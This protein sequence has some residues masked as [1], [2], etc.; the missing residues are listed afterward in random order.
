VGAKI[1][2]EAAEEERQDGDPLTV[3]QLSPSKTVSGCPENSG[4]SEWN[5]NGI[6]Q[7][8]TPTS[9]TPIAVSPMRPSRKRVSSAG[10]ESDIEP[11]SAW[12]DEWEERY[13]I[14][15]SNREGEVRGREGKS[16]PQARRTADGEKASVQPSDKKTGVASRSLTL[17]RRL[18][19]KAVRQS[20][21]A[22]KLR[23]KLGGRVGTGDTGK[24]RTG[25]GIAPKIPRGG[26]AVSNAF[27]FSENT[28]T[29][30]TASVVRPEGKGSNRSAADDVTTGPTMPYIGDNVSFLSV[31]L[32]V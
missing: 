1:P 5:D 6:R 13:L 4:S 14:T 10:R 19:A 31:L 23:D 11:G 29:S 21:R 17:T 15:E 24:G 28:G 18:K 16:V 32:Q 9:G 12:P 27:R 3:P 2:Q 25:I 20:P 26:H 30:T 8:P 7:S 22:R